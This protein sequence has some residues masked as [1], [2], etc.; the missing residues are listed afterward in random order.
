MKE[1][2]KSER[3]LKIAFFVGLIAV[4]LIFLSSNG[5]KEEVTTDN[6]YEARLFSVL[7][8]M[9]G[10]SKE[11]PPEILV[12]M[13]KDNITVL[14]VVVVSESADSPIIKERML[15]AVSK[16]LDVSPSRIC[17]TN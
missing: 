16:A 2:L 7:T 1:L 12:K 3:L 17:I 8:Q 15:D 10:V 11:K 13:D 6:H 5:K 9:E 4:V 14:G